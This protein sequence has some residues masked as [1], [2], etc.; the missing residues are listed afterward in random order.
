VILLTVVLFIMLLSL[1]VLYFLKYHASELT[2]RKI[3]TLK[4]VFDS[5]P[6]MVFCM[7]TSGKYMECNHRYEEFAGHSQSEI[8]GR[9]PREIYGFDEEM[10]AY[11]MDTDQNVM[12]K[13][14]TLKV[15]EWV[16]NPDL[17]RRMLETIKAPL[18]LNGKVIGLLGISRDIT[19]LHT[20]MET[21]RMAS[22]AKTD[23]LARMSHEMRTP[24]N[25][26]IGLSELI[27]ETE[28]LNPQSQSD[29]EKVSSAGSTLLSTVND[30]LDISKIEAGKLELI[31]AEYDIPNLINDT[32]TQSIMYIGEKPIEFRLD[33]DESLPVH[34]FGDDLRIKQVLNNLL[35]NACKYTMAG[36]VELSIR[37]QREGDIVWFN[38]SIRDSGVGIKEENLKNLFDNYFQIDTVSHRKIE[39]T[40]LGLSITKKIIDMM[41]GTITVESQYGS[42]SVFSLKLKQKFVN[43]STLN[44]DVINSLKSFR[45]SVSRRYRSNEYSRMNMK[46]ARVLVVDDNATNLDVAR[47]MLKLYGM[48]VD[49]VNS[50]PLAIEA[51]REQNVKYDAVFMDHMM[52]GMDG[53]EA[54]RII[55]EE[56]GTDYAKTIPVIALTANAI[57]GNDEMFL[58]KG[59]Q[60]FISK[61]INREHLDSVIRQWIKEPQKDKNADVINSEPAEI[62]EKR[63]NKER[64]INTNRRSGLERRTFG[65]VIPGIDFTKGKERFGDDEETYLNVLHS[66]TIN[67]RPLLE[68][69][70]DP[71]SEKLEEYAVIVHGIK[72]SS[73]GIQANLLGNQAME[74]EKAAKE[75]NFVYVRSNNPVFLDAANKLMADIDEFLGV[76]D[77]KSN[78]PVRQKPEDELLSRLADGCKNYDVDEI[79]AAMGEIEKSVYESDDGLVCW[80]RDNIDQ[81][82][83]TLIIEKLKKAG[84]DEK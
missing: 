45:Y 7:D 69:I 80:L 48:T 57:T 28:T 17:S 52:P 47:G 50:G 46:Y 15:E 65:K 25:A 27:L 11:F 2:N 8:I 37:C 73:Y 23:F 51:I 29:L 55:R 30:I 16:T 72:G 19:D 24:L 64:R 6:D 22:L 41:G 67:T 39:G 81:M 71:V 42:G 14:I 76:M 26:V 33:I 43:D 20:A 1:A 75:G 53:I 84:I 59:F 78:K 74:L 54:V 4:S 32:V 35:S 83:Y 9:T 12:E 60:A 66:F 58:Q 68:T 31:P 13:R 77:A 5:M 82:N 40:G 79:D 62:L 3:H 70:K 38:A 56:I 61:P 36:F 34:L 63:S 49:C 21:A 44:I 18:I 10:A